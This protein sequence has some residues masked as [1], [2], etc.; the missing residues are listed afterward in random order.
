MS[1]PIAHVVTSYNRPE[2]MALQATQYPENMFA[3][4][5]ATTFG[6]T[7]PE[8]AILTGWIRY[9]LV[10]RVTVGGGRNLALAMA[11]AK[12]G[13]DAIY[14]MPDDDIVMKHDEAVA[15]C[16]DFLEKNPQHGVIQPMSSFGFNAVRMREEFLDVMRIPCPCSIVFVHG[17]LLEA[18]GYHDPTMF[19]KEDVDFA[20]RAWASGHTPAIYD[21]GYERTVKVTKFA[22]KGGFGVESTRDKTARRREIRD[23]YIRRGNEKLLE[24]YPWAKITANGSFTWKRQFDQIYADARP[25][26]VR[27]RRCEPLIPLDVLR[28]LFEGEWHPDQTA[29]PPACIASESEAGTNQ[30]YATEPSA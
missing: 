17:R 3:C 8:N 14:F 12:L 27:E 11:Y 4:R 10:D 7:Q 21:C 16:A 25:T 23:G 15:E 9:A 29:L 24:M 22:S 5:V 30:P 18:I 28:G 2:A 6:R 13:P 19:F 26:I 20:I 1:L